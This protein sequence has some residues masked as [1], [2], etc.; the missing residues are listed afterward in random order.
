MLS[1]CVIDT[2]AV[3]LA[4]ANLADN[5][6]NHHVGSLV[7]RVRDVNPNSVIINNFIVFYILDVSSV[8]NLLKSSHSLT[9][10]SS[11]QATDY[12]VHLGMNVSLFQS[13]SWLRIEVLG[14]INRTQISI[15]FTIPAKHTTNMSSSLKIVDLLFIVMSVLTTSKR[16]NKIQE[17]ISLNHMVSNKLFPLYTKNG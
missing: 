13:R 3:F 12:I 15:G 9:S 1:V 14:S 4:L 2:I 6:H 5:C 10:G 8:I 17:H 16:R 11:I 7:V